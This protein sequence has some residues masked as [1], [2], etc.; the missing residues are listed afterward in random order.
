MTSCYFPFFVTR[1][2]NWL[3]RWNEINNMSHNK[4]FFALELANKEESVQFQT[5]SA[6]HCLPP[7]CYGSVCILEIDCLVKIYV[8]SLS[9]QSMCGCAVWHAGSQRQILSSERYFTGTKMAYRHLHK[10]INNQTKICLFLS[11]L[12]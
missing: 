7:L 3:C 2:S 5:V 10:N 8:T 1:F 9:P 11:P 12:S 4:S 6:T